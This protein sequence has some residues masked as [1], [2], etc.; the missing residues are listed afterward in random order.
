M[1]EKQIESKIVRLLRES[2]AW[3][4]QLQSWRV[5]IKKWP[6]SNMMHLCSKWTPDIIAFYKGTFYAI[7]VKKD[8]KEV[9]KWYKLEAR[10]IQGETLPLSYD[11]ELAQIEHKEL[12][13]R[14]WGDHI[15]S[16][17]PIE[18]LKFIWL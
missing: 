18:V 16:A 10:Y 11:R 15:V 1:A 7:E 3:C 12:I 8:Q 5:L 6:Y 13:E 9:D 2:W 4:E 14:N 17:N